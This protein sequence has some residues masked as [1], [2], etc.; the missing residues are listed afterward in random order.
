MKKLFYFRRH[1]ATKPLYHLS[2]KVALFLY[3]LVIAINYRVPV[4]PYILR[5]MEVL[6]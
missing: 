6:H 4:R 2:N 5:I 1:K 3:Y